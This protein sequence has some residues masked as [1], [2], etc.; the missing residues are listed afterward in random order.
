MSDSTGA[1][2]PTALVLAGAWSQLISVSLALL[3]CA[4][5]AFADG[6]ALVSD[7]PRPVPASLTALHSDLKF[8]LV[9]GIRADVTGDETGATGLLAR[10]TQ[11]L[12]PALE[13]AARGL[14]PKMMARVARFDVY[15]AQSA[16]V[17]T[18][19]S[20]AG[21]IAIG[22]ALADLRL[23]DDALAFVIAREMGHV[24]G[25]H[26]EDNS[27]ASIVTSIIMNLLLP[28]SSLIKSAI[29][30]AS[31]ELAASSDSERQ[32]KEADEIAV[33]LLE[34]AGYRIRNL[35]LS[36]ATAPVDQ[37]TGS[38]ARSFR[39]STGNIV[40]QARPLPVTPPALSVIA[41]AE[42]GTPMSTSHPPEPSRFSD[43]PLIR[44]RPSGIAGPL[45]LG[46]YAVPSRRVD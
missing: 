22:S 5:S 40:A 8:S 2:R 29:S 23:T 7:T 26:H 43:E 28:G 31:S 41:V 3:A 34:T 14:Y 37:G 11:R 13:S 1:Y 21:K 35:A 36:L 44:A 46:G 45:L 42:A 25:G 18:R 30:M 15:V 17:E 9:T 39:Q 32:A 20:P 16:D 12:V 24:L 19:S 10:Q 6:D 27:A 33:R 4:G 38:W